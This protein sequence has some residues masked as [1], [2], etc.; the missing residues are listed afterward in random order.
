M[1]V[2][3]QISYSTLAPPGSLTRSM[4]RSVL[5]MGGGSFAIPRGVFHYNFSETRVVLNNADKTPLRMLRICSSDAGS[6]GAVPTRN[7]ILQF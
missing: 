7:A 2:F 4:L 6:L 1:Y 5:G 3:E